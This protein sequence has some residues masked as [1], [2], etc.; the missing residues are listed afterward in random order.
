M[1][2]STKIVATLGPASDPKIKELIN[3]GVDVFRLN[4]SYGAHEEHAARIANIRSAASGTGR[5]VAI[6]ADL[7]GPKIRIGGFASEPF[8]LAPGDKFSID[9]ALPDDGG[10]RGEV[11][12]KFTALAEQVSPEDVL[13]LGDE[14]LELEVIDIK[15]TRVNCVVATGGEVRAGKGINLR[16]G[17]LYAA[18]P[19]AR[20]IEDLKFACDQGVDYLAI[21]FT[22]SADDLKTARKLVEERGSACAIVAKIE[23]AEAVAS[24]ANMDAIIKASDAV[25]VAR[26]DLAIEIGEAALMGMQ[27]HIIRRSRE[28]NR[29]VITATQMMESMVENAH[30]TRAEIMDVSNAVLDGTDA[31]ML[32]AET[33]T[34]K[35]P[36]ETVQAMVRVILGAESTPFA[37]PQTSL[38]HDCEAI[39]ES[40][41][42]AAMTV[43][44][45]LADVR[46]VACLTSSGNTPKLMSRSRS[47]LPIYALGNNPRTL[48]RAAL[49]RG[50]HPRLFET[51]S[52]DYALV[53]EAVV[54]FL[55]QIG[56]VAHGDVVI[57]SKGDLEDVQGGTNT[58]KV[59][60]VD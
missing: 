16:G 11:S 46:A 52:Y 2:R 44:E 48:S 6:L 18:T 14:S 5:H 37:A 24:D 47:R 28:L 13:L 54:E 32:S 35:Y 31:V 38:D 20:D 30:P 34:G 43:A 50:V 21:S 49:Y 1:P 9:P 42:L 56:A 26:G 12:T 58:L 22:S 59:L 40:I 39:D 15:G 53:N 45:H 36:V 23:K 8:E 10:N 51:S 17:G 3:A 29:C 19:T 4:F 55:V 27:K 41:A 57:L 33:A 7:Q 25:M 60:E